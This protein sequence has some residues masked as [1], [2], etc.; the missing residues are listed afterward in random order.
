[1]SPGPN[2]FS[3]AR[4]HAQQYVGYVWTQL[5]SVPLVAPTSY[6]RPGLLGWNGGRTESPLISL[7]FA[8]FL[9]QAGLL[10]WVEGS[11]GSGLFTHSFYNPLPSTEL[12]LAPTSSAMP[13][14]KIMLQWEVWLV[15]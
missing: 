8:T 12:C 4:P 7:I 2:T 5:L 1:M 13:I 3:I 9:D 10:C 6:H 15:P 14:L 11:Y